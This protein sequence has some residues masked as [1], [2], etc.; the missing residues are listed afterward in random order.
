MLLS[1]S[2]PL[3]T[4]YLTDSNNN[5]A[6]NAIPT[7][8]NLTTVLPSTR[9]AVLFSVWLSDDDLALLLPTFREHECAQYFKAFLDVFN[10]KC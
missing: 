2:L 4:H 10:S 6:L 5:S 1:V 8:L 9:L 7:N 3:L